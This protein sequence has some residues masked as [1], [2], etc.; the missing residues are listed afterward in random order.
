MGAGVLQVIA[1]GLG[2]T[3][4]PVALDDGTIWVVS[5]THGC[6][7][8]LTSDGEIL[9]KVETGGGPNGLAVDRDGALYVAQN[10]GAWG[11]T[12]DTPAGIQKVVNGKVELILEVG[13]APN[14]L[15]F[16]PDGRLYFTDP[17][18]GSTEPGAAD[19]VDPDD[20][21][22]VD[23]GQLYS[24]ERDGSDVKLLWSGPKLINGL[25]FGRDADEL[26]VA[27]TAQ[28]H[29]IWRASFTR[30]QL[31]HFTQFVV[32][33][34]GRPDGIAVGADGSVWVGTGHNNKVYCFGQDGEL[35]SEVE[36][37]PE[38][39]SPLNLCFGGRN[40]TDLFIA[41]SDLGAVGRVDVGEPGLPLLS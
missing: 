36:C 34:R 3:E 11:G 7:Y 13:E 28:P 19:Y 40:N 10:G 21:S 31:G 15:C 37:G 14:D 35:R 26:F 20:A 22:T 8:H 6:L 33:E 24:C 27:E 1:D 17:H 30:G 2:F 25:A 38:F 9:E 32:L 12:K 16:G 5:I 41:L 18:G 39:S 29:R 4:G 23:P